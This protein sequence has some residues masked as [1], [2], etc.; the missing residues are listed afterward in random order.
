MPPDAAVDL[1]ARNARHL[2]LDALK[3]RDLNALDVGVGVSLYKTAIT[4]P[5]EETPHASRP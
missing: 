5:R 3:R 2:I 4:S 1:E